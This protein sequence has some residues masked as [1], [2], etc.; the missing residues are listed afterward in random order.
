M[1]LT[2]ETPIERLLH[3]ADELD[4]SAERMK[5]C[6]FYGDPPW[7]RLQ[8]DAADKRLLALTLKTQFEKDK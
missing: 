3:E 7:L 4:L 8:Q 6:S 5:G 1:M 2:T